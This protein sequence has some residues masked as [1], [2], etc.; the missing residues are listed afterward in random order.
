MPWLLKNPII[1]VTW[2]NINHAKSNSNKWPWC[3]K[4]EIAPNE[5]FSQKKKK[6]C[7]Y[8]PLSFCKILKEFKSGSRVIRMCHFWAQNSTFVLNKTCLV[9]TIIITLIYLLA[10]F[11]VQNLQTF[12]TVVPN[13]WGCPIFGPKMVHLPRKNFF[14]KIL[15]SFSS[16]Y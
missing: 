5:I 11:I 1:T 6:S 7:T 15:I 10:I 2:P 9:Q 13:L 3:E 12:F 4:D 16:N 8:Y 14:G